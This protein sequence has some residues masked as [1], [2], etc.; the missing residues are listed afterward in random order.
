MPFSAT[1]HNVTS[2]GCEAVDALFSLRAEILRLRA[3]EAELC[4]EIL[5]F[6][7]ESGCDKVQGTDR[8]AVIETR[9]PLRL[10]PERLPQEML[11]DAGLFEP[12]V[13]TVVLLAPR[14]DTREVSRS[15][16]NAETE[17]RPENADCVD[18][19]D[20]FG[21]NGLT[22]HNTG[23]SLQQA[24]SL[25]DPALAEER[26]APPDLRPTE[27]AE[28]QPLAG[29]DQDILAKIETDA[30]TALEPA[31]LPDALELA[32]QLEAEADMHAAREIESDSQSPALPD[33]AFTS[34]RL[35]IG[36]ES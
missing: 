8:I 28:L 27:H 22:S 3:R 13:E 1:D 25:L 6:A 12:R 36:G 29:L 35:A 30:E 23:T 14:V 19:D 9:R 15:E 7:T 10:V 26:D 34:R 24:S 18:A 17:S 4:D 20:P 5:T 21:L 11:L 16:P 33:T 32:Q 2:T 31:T